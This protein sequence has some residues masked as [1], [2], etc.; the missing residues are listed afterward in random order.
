MKKQLLLFL[1]AIVFSQL[2][3][4]SKTHKIALSGSVFSNATALPLKLPFP[5]H[6][7]LTV[8]GDFPLFK[9]DKFVQTVKLGSY[10]HN[11]SQ[12]A[13]QLYTET[14][15]VQP[16]GETFSARA[17]LGGGYLLSVTKA[18]SFKFENGSYSQASQLR[19]QAM[20][21]T[22]MSVYY[23]IVPQYLSLF[24]SYQFWFQ[25]PFVKGYVPVLPNTSLHIGISIKP[26]NRKFVPL[27]MKPNKK[28]DTKVYK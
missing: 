20:A 16:I 1:T 15:F 19:N 3:H 4:A 14:N 13:F 27:P 5:V 11:F 24:T 21:S 12:H 6:P 17:G 2:L 25:M 7:G 22:S 23:A 8:G 10:F 28:V 26:F 18:E 9:S